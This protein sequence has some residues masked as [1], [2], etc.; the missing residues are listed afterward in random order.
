MKKNIVIFLI[1]AMITCLVILITYMCVIKGENAGENKFEDI[2]VG[3]YVFFG[4]YEQDNNTSNGKEDI[5]WL[6]LDV[7]DG[8]ALLIS[9]YALDCK[10][11][12]TTLTDV[13]WETCTLRK[14]LNDDFIN[15][16]FSREEQAMISE[17]TVNADKNPG[18]DTNSGNATLD[19]VFLL[20]ITEANK[21]FFS[22]KER[23]CEPTV[24]AVANGAREEG[25]SGCWWWL[26]SPGVYQHY[27]SDIISILGDVMVSKSGTDVNDTCNAVRPAMWIEVNT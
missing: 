10:P 26:R 20:S 11:Y 19:K 2:K 4:T 15:S 17:V 3:D 25:V 6:V 7:Q 9:K 22:D 5:E 18:Y 13:T 23:R 27:A 1:S 21:Y 14:W 16:A 8:K 12:N 24:Y